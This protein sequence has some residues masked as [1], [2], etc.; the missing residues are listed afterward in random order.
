M[1]YVSSVPYLS[2]KMIRPMVA[3]PKNAT[4]PIFYLNLV[5]AKNVKITF[6]KMKL[7]KPVTKMLV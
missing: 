3:F 7:E 5:I 2:I 6:I 4:Q 1:V